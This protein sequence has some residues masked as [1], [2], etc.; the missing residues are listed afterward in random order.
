MT[1]EQKQK[2]AVA[3]SILAMLIALFSCA[4]S[5]IIALACYQP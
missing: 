1:D 3:I 2:L 5:W 4:L